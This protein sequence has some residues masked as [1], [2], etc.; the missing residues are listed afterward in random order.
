MKGKLQTGTMNGEQWWEICIEK[1]P[2]ITAD[3]PAF[4]ASEKSARRSAKRW[5][6]RLGIEL[7]EG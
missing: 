7:V 5:A 1:G 4:F 6:G 3:N 2:C